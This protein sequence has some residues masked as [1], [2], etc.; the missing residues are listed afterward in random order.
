MILVG[1]VI[2]VLLAAA[3]LRAMFDPKKIKYIIWGS[4]WGTVIAILVMAYLLYREYELVNF[5]E[6][7]SPIIIFYLDHQ[8]QMYH[9][10]R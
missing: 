6:Y 2:S 3:F 10:C 4:I 7:F 5:L 1:L 8:S 9:G